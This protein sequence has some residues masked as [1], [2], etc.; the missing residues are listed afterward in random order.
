VPIS[1]AMPDKS[2]LVFLRLYGPVELWLDKDLEAWGFR[3]GWVMCLSPSAK[4][5]RHD[6][7]RRR[8]CRDSE[9]EQDARSHGG[10]LW[11]FL[12]GNFSVWPPSPGCVINRSMSAISMGTNADKFS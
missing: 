12:R 1:Q 8:A 9:S 7:G 10:E 11:G 3:E 4:K 2:Y 5:K 6:W